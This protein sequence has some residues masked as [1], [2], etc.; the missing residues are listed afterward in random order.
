[1]KKKG[2]WIGYDA[3]FKIN[4]NQ[5]NLQEGR[6]NL[7]LQPTDTKLQLGSGGIR[8]QVKYIYIKKTKDKI[9]HMWKLI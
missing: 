5:K 9:Y 3:K 8:L 4:N 7:E 2:K 6:S 1:M